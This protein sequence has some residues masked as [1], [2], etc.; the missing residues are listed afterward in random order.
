MNL[1]EIKQRGSKNLC[2]NWINVNK[3]RPISERIFVTKS[4]EYTTLQVIRT[5]L[6]DLQDVESKT[7]YQNWD[8]TKV[9]R[10]KTK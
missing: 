4:R 10:P 5:I 3:N 1:S 8:Q 9:L 2:L 7:K 6:K